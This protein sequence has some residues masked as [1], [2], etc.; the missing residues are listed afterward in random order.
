MCYLFCCC[1]WKKPTGKLNISQQKKWHH[2]EHWASSLSPL[3][4]KEQEKHDKTLTLSICNC[5]KMFSQRFRWWVLSDVCVP[6]RINSESNALDTNRK[7]TP[8]HH[9]VSEVDLTRKILGTLNEQ[10]CPSTNNP[11]KAK[12][13]KYN[14]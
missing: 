2:C 10:H 5:S 3:F 1:S 12:F 9:Y 6:D 4:I 14:C 7:D 13:S 11:P 8:C